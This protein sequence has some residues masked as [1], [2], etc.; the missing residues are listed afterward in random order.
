MMIDALKSKSAEVEISN[1]RTHLGQDRWERPC[2]ASLN[3][4]TGPTVGGVA[5]SAVRR[6]SRESDRG[7]GLPRKTP[8][9]QPFPFHHP[10]IQCW[11]RT[12]NEILGVSR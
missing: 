11:E 2:P 9:R 1:F 5:L 6:E 8:D 12:Q 3:G 7:R 4:I 10:P